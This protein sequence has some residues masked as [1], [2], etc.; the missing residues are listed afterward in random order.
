MNSPS[1]KRFAFPLATALCLL[2]VAPLCARV[3]EEEGWT[4]VQSKN[5]RLIGNARERDIRKVAE[6]LEQ[7]REAFLRLLSV[8]H[9]DSSVPLTVIVFKDDAAYTPFEPLFSGQPAGIAGFFQ[10][11]PDID[12]IT[13][14]V[15]RKHVRRPDALAFHEYVH[16]LVRNSF[17]NAP[18]WFNE[19]LAEYYSTF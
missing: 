15:D 5:F 4:S 6:R 19:G 9:F 1:V 18:L 16:L 8:N 7:F 12:Y 14:S 13:L 10:S 2:L 3:K 17:G 11:S